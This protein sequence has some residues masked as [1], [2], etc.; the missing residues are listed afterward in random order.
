M[1]ATASSR[2]R[3]RGSSGAPAW[4]NAHLFLQA[5]PYLPE[6]GP[7]TSLLL[8]LRCLLAS[9]ELNVIGLLSDSKDAIIGAARR[10]EVRYAA[11][12]RSSIAVGLHSPPAAY[13]LAGP[14]SDRRRSR[15]LPTK[16]RPPDPNLI[17]GGPETPGDAHRRSQ[18]STQATDAGRCRPL[19]WQHRA[20]RRGWGGRFSEAGHAD[21]R[22]ASGARR[23]E[24][25]LQHVLR[26]RMGHP[27]SSGHQEPRPSPILPIREFQ[28][29]VRELQVV[30]RGLRS[31]IQP[32]TGGLQGEGRSRH[33]VGEAVGRAR[34]VRP[35]YQHPP[36]GAGR[37][38]GR[39]GIWR[40]QG[41]Q[42]SRG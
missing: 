37:Q 30:I 11:P 14:T 20:D 7:S 35:P 23:R 32:P 1:Q 31:H 19:R 39:Q 36:P 13:R 3:V 15:C 9:L 42:S 34:A 24:V 8:D 21:A 16:R 5:R 18:R 38:G 29:V 41:R 27:S 10:R 22:Q 12:H 2:E 28:P 40:R 33:A 26:R 25:T 6:G 17:E 4:W